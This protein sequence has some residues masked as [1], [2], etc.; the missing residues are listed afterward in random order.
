MD[1][2]DKE[3]KK[4]LTREQ[5][6]VLRRRGTERP[7]SGELLENRANGEY[8]CAG[9]GSVVFDSSTKYDSTTPG[10]IGWPSFSDAV[11]RDAVQLLGDSSLGM[12]RTE[13]LCSRCGGHL[14]H[15]FRDDS[16]SNGLHYCINS[17]AL[18]FSEGDKS[19]GPESES[20]LEPSDGIGR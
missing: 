3:W 7:F 18:E 8:A 6:N 4:K 12:Q 13:V 15:L 19:A 2:S 20:S 14:G 9:C 5:Y 16:S 11:S 10:L 1:L 17:C